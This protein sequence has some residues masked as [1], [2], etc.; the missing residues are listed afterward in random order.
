LAPPP[1]QAVPAVELLDH[2][3]THGAVREAEQHGASQR[4]IEPGIRAEPRGE[5]GRVD[6]EAPDV[7]DRRLDRL[8]VRLD[9]GSLRS[10]ATSWLP[11]G[12]PRGS[13]PVS[14]TVRLPSYSQAIK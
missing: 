5:S 12:H 11:N 14:A 9:H 6:D 8:L 1:P 7:G 3:P 2:P 4:G 13:V 10:S